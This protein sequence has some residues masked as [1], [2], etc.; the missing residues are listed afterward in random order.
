MVERRTLRFDVFQVC[1]YINARHK[2]EVE[3]STAVNSEDQQKHVCVYR[4]AIYLKSES[5][6]VLANVRMLGGRK[7]VG[8]LQ[9]Y[10]RRCDALKGNILYIRF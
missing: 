10:D 6:A 8:C 9:V 2:D 7:R 4:I 3:S 5:D 1:I